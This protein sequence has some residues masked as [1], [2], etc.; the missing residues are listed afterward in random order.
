MTTWRRGL[1]RGAWIAFLVLFAAWV[2]AGTSLCEWYG[3]REPPPGASHAVATHAQAPHGLVAGLKHV[4]ASPMGQASHDRGDQVCEELAYLPGGAQALPST[5]KRSLTVDAIPWSHAPARNWA[6][7]VV[8]ASA[9]PPQW[10]H[11][12]PSRSPLD[13]SPRL[14]I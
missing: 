5:I 11:P 1:A 3:E 10:V 14:R 2:I 12:P 9:S 7:A 8:M 6:P 4:G 13:I